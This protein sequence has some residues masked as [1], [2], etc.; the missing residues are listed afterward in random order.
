MARLRVSAR[1]STETVSR[2]AGR[3]T[4]RLLTPLLSDPP[5]VPECKPPPVS[6]QQTAAECPSLPVAAHRDTAWRTQQHHWL[7]AVAAVAVIA[8]VAGWL[9]GQWHLLR[10]QRNRRK[11]LVQQ[12][13]ATAATAAAVQAAPDTA[14]LAVAEQA[15]QHAA[16]CSAEKATPSAV[17]HQSNELAS[18]EQS[19][20]L[21]PAA[22]V[23]A[24][25]QPA[26]QRVSSHADV[27]ASSSSQQ[28]SVS[29]PVREGASPATV[30]PPAQRPGSQSAARQVWRM[31][32]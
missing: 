28:E 32:T 1:E 26:A 12:L 4:A 11:Q 29:E 13:P 17:S 14:S 15:Q 18:P 25:E 27:S 5:A 8:F 6:S 30:Q 9:S 7:L 22:A 24:A 16:A 20:A 23:S 21:Q 2:H 31:Y 3:I 19:A 10:R